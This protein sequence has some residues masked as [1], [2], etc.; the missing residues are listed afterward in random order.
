[1]IPDSATK[2]YD[3]I[4]FDF[5]LN[6]TNGFF[7]LL[8]RLRERYPDAVLI[9]VHIW[10]ILSIARYNG[11]PPSN[12]DVGLNPDLDW[13]W[14][15]RGD[16]FNPNGIP[17]KHCPREIC[18]GAVMEQLTIDAGGYIYKLP[19]P[20]TPKVA[21][22]NGWFGPDWQHLS[23]RGH[24]VLANGILEILHSHETE[25]KSGSKRLGTF[26]LGDQCF[27]WF[28]NGIVQPKFTGAAL[29]NLIAR[30]T[31]RDPNVAKWV[32][33][34]DSDYVGTITFESKFS[35][36]V[37]IGLSYMSKQQESSYTIVEISVNS[38][39]NNNHEVASRHTTITIDPNYN[40]S[41][42]TT[43]ITVYSHV[44]WA[45]P[46][47]NTITIR[48]V[49][50]RQ[51]PFRVVGIFL[52]GHCAERGGDMGNGAIRSIDDGSKEEQ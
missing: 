9:Y 12:G 11:K 47:L 2:H 16:T 10:N 31:Q 36:R 32:M 5:V 7:L 24:E 35:I 50:K 44:G 14:G 21:L 48:T 28:A 19:L 45:N 25:V 26:G 38:S 34:M 33:E 4:L 41:G 30:D 18:D 49:E 15:N 17:S 20:P 42:P 29:V 13:E 6:G 39:D 3:V 1:M 37:P 22:A 40:L 46:G 27:Q 51:L 8:K 52:C 43:H 23:N